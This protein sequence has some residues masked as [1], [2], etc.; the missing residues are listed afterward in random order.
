MIDRKTLV[1]ALL[2]GLLAL[3]LFMTGAA[4]DDDVHASEMWGAGAAYLIGAGVT[5]KYVKKDATL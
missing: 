4:A 5:T 1:A 2:G 3:C